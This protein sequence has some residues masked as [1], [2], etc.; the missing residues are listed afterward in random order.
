LGVPDG[1]GETMV[2]AVVALRGTVTEKELTAYCYGQLA[3]YKVPR[4]IAI[5]GELPRGPAGK[6]R[7]RPED[8][9]G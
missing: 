6:V 9:D 2:A 5:R 4:R 7:L 3:D 8:L 1:N